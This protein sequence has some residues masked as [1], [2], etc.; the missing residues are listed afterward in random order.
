M[1]N[2]DIEGSRILSEKT[3]LTQIQEN[4]T[5]K[6]SPNKAQEKEC[7]N[8]QHPTNNL[9]F[10]PEMVAR[11]NEPKPAISNGIYSSLSSPESNQ[12]LKM[13]HQ[14]S[15]IKDQPY[16]VGGGPDQFS[17]LNTIDSN[18]RKDQLAPADFKL[19][20][21]VVNQ[22]L[23]ESRTSETQ[24]IDEGREQGP[25]VTINLKRSREIKVRDERNQVAQEVAPG[26]HRMGVSKPSSLLTQSPFK[27]SRKVSKK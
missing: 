15:N 13:Q 1:T 7:S 16:L 12:L 8:S 21:S 4:H 22:K 26:L 14:F 23:I 24:T 5:G 10:S 9:A 6:N 2:K 20:P 27:H 11:I 18:K 25:V 17:T 19:K 3:E